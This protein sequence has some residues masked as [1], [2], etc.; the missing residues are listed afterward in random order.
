MTTLRE[1]ETIT[2]IVAIELTSTMIE[3]NLEKM[4]M[5][6]LNLM[7]E[8]IWIGIFKKYMERVEEEKVTLDSENL[9]L[10]SQTKADI[11][12]QAQFKEGIDKETKEV[13]I[14]ES[15]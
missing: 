14:R 15:K 11:L 10:L 1:S 13:E 4:M 7:E 8:K 12:I 6:E 3:I 9:L 2:I 5:M